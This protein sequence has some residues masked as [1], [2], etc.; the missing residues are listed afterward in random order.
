MAQSVTMIWGC[1][2]NNSIMW[3]DAAVLVKDQAEVTIVSLISTSWM[4]ILMQRTKMELSLKQIFRIWA[5][6]LS[7]IALFL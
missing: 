5:I 6:I 1:V 7:L 2:R 4:H 3:G